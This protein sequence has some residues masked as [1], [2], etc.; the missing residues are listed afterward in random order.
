VPDEDLVLDL[1]A[2]ADERVARDLAGDADRCPPLHLHEGSDAGVTPDAAAVK[3]AE[4][5]DG[6]V[7]TELDAV[8]HRKATALAGLSPM[9]DRAIPAEE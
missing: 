8:D 1:N 5:P 6:H 3:V 9:C 4:R 2:V 7:F